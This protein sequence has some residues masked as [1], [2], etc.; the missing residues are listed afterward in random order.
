[1]SSVYYIQVRNEISGSYSGK[2][3]NDSSG[4]LQHVTSESDVSE[5]R[6][7]STIGTVTVK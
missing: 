2:Y 5:V 1:M 6:T 4:M 3:D 7:A